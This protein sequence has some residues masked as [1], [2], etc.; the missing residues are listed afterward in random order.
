MLSRLLSY[1]LSQNSALSQ[2]SEGAGWCSGTT[3]VKCTEG[4]GF[5]KPGQSSSHEAAIKYSFGFAECYCQ[6][7]KEP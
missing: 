6:N 4:P 7:M 1:V 3:L 2:N 5:E